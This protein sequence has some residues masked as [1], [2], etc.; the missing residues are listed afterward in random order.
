LAQG[1]RQTR[2][3]V[4]G[5]GWRS[6]G[7]SHNGVFRQPGDKAFIPPIVI[8]FARNSTTKLPF[9]HGLGD[10]DVVAATEPSR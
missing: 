9:E 3:T 5:E 1:I 6:G 8:V 4:R 2:E 10:E 7:L